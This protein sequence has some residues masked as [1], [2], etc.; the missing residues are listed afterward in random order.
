MLTA[1]ARPQAELKRVLGEAGV[2]GLEEARN[3]LATTVRLNMVAIP[4][5]CPIYYL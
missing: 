1:A 2:H 4:R 5:V 3:V